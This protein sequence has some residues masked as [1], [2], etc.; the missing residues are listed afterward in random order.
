MK[1]SD[2]DN[3]FKPQILFSDNHI[4]VAIKPPGMVVPIE[5]NQVENLEQYLK[6]YFQN[7]LGKETVFIRPIHRID[8]PV[9]GIVVFAR[10]SKAIKRLQQSQRDG[11]IK[12]FYVAKVHGSVTKSKE[13]LTHELIHGDYRAEI[14]KSGG[15][16]A[17]LYYRR[18]KSNHKESLLSIRLLTG[19]YHQI[20]IQ[21]SSIG[22]PIIGDN[23]YGS[24]QKLERHKILLYHTKISFPHPT[25]RKRMVFT[26]RPDYF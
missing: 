10:S 3:H 1:S 23:K 12:K 19:R 17:R 2:K 15:K 14:V 26:A 20:R 13:V 11:D 24:T 25:T 7:L 9:G 5:N 6:S 16:E 4:C 22:H 21:L 8:K 18:L